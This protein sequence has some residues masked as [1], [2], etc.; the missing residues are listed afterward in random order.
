MTPKRLRIDICI[1]LICPWCQIGLRQFERARALLRAEQP[2]VEFDLHWH[3]QTLLPDL[4]KEG[5][6][7]TEF[8]EERLG[9]AEAVAARQA[10]VR[11]AG[12]TVGL[13][14]AFERI[15]RM[16]H[17]GLAQALLSDA[18]TQLRPEAFEQLLERLFAAH[19]QRGESLCDP[20]LLAALAHEFGVIREVNTPAPPQPEL[21]APS[22]PYFIFDRL[23]GLGGARDPQDLLAMMR[24][25]LAR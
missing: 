19:F 10:Q 2:N 3:L 9:S 18:S 14:F 20:Q 7:F 22:V 21:R 6:P 24:Q 8:Y 13:D 11:E 16:P 12:R 5:R 1:D 4:P 17:T 25:A 15:Q 23:F